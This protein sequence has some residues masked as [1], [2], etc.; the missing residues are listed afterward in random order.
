MKL[1]SISKSLNKTIRKTT[2]ILDKYSPEI[3]IGCGLVGFVTTVLL[4]AHEAPIARDSLNDLHQDLAER[5]DAD[6]LSKGRIIFEEA[7]V[8]TPIYLPSIISGGVACACILG[9]YHI[10]SR[11]TAAIAACYEF[12]Q[13]NLVEYQKKVVEKLGEKK[14]REIRHEIQEDKVKRNAIDSYGGVM[15]GQDVIYTDGLYLFYDSF[16]GRYFRS[17]V[18]IVRKAEKSIAERLVTEMWISLNEFYW[19]LGIGNT[20]VGDELGF[21]VEDGIDL[22]LESCQLPDGTTCTA[23]TYLCQPRYEALFK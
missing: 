3:L 21:N 5:E 9:S 14:E 7:K 15:G 1:N 20:D 13:S 22:S 16:T 19:E 2:K 8:V 17:N 6:K 18:D 10:S 4:V 23:I 12:A 11:R